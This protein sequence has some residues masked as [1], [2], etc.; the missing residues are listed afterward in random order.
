MKRCV[1]AVSV[2]WVTA[3][4]GAAPVNLVPSTPGS[5][6]D[7]L[8]TWNLQ[9]YVTSCDI[10]KMRAAMCE[11]NMFGGGRFQDW[12]GLYPE[13][14]SDLIFVMDDSWDVSIAD[15]HRAS[16]ADDSMYGSLILSEDRFPSFTGTPPERLKKLVQAVKARGW[17]GLGGWVCAQE[18]PAFKDIPFEKYW[19]ERLQWMN[20][21]GFSYWKVDWGKSCK[22]AEWRRSL[23]DLSRK[24]APSLIMEHVMVEEAVRFA[25]AY[26]TYDVENINAVAPTVGRIARLLKCDPLYPDAGIINCE[27]EPYIA[28]GTGCAIGVMRHPFR[29]DFPNG[30]MDFCF[31][32]VGRDIKNRL[33]EVIRGVRWHRIASPFPVSS[34]GVLIDD[35]LIEDY[36]MAKAGETWTGRKD[37]DRYAEKSNPRISR[38][39]PLC[40]VKVSGDDPVPY[41]LASRYP[42]GAIAVSSIGRTLGR[43]YHAPNAELKLAIGK[44]TGPVGIFGS[45]KSLTLVL[46]QP[47]GAV[48]VLGQDLASDSASDI[49]KE[50]VVNGDAITFPGELIRR[51]GLSAAHKGDL[52]EPG[53]VVQIALSGTE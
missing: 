6:P 24:V 38:N 2:A 29:G 12:L 22:D 18:A 25:H 53:M 21:A 43:K 34:K 42:N 9:G 7:Y 51:V 19:T 10:Q 20:D 4:A 26:R 28:V 36:W 3:L 14:R 49:T 30:N 31:P 13:I 27:D 15:S 1:L 17:K 32:P 41:V 35:D 47:V 33:D 48:T 39:L 46:D 16:D 52:S 40:E 50:V 45:C 23:A 8:C 37:G 11:E 5:A 44:A